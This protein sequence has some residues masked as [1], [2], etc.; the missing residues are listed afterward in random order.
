MID[1][2]PTAAALADAL[3]SAAPTLDPGE[4]RLAL[5]LYRLLLRGRPVTV[6][7]LASDVGVDQRDGE[8]ALARWPGVFRDRKGRTVGFWGLVVRGMPHKMSTGAGDITTWCALDPLLIAPLVTDRARVQSLDPSPAHRSVSPSRQAASSMSSRPHR[9]SRC[10]IP[11]AAL[12]TT[13]SRAFAISSTS[14]HPSSPA[15]NGS[16]SI[17]GRFSSPSMRPST[18]RL[19]H[20]LPC[21]VRRWRK[22][23][24][25]SAE[26]PIGAR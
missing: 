1:A 15:S 10:S 16:P 13:S 14:S 5:E 21:S 11:R 3:T 9:S 7:D 26:G 8:T 23:A 6:S 2:R 17:L 22:S 20:G 4:Q 12:A 19:D 18:W 25:T 24:E